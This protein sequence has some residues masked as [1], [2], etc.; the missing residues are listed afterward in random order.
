MQFFDYCVLAKLEELLLQYIVPAIRYILL[1][2]LKLD[3]H[4]AFFCSQS[5]TA[6]A[7]PKGAPDLRRKRQPAAPTVRNVS[8]CRGIRRPG[9]RKLFPPA[10][11]IAAPWLKKRRHC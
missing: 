3:C 5:N 9:A 8:K 1:L 7:A 4:H 11:V 2:K 6:E 10:E